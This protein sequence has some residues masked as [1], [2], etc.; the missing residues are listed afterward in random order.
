CDPHADLR[1]S[2][3]FV[4]FNCIEECPSGSLSFKLLPAGR[5]EI[6]WPEVPGRRAVLA[7]VAGLLLYPF[8]RTSGK[9]TRDYSSKVIRPPGT[10]EELEFLERCIK[11]DQCVR[12]CPTNVLQPAGMEA[13]VEGVW[14]PVMNFRMGHCQL[15]CTAC[16]QVCPTGAI[17][18]ISLEE[19]LG[20]GEFT[21]RGPIRLGTAH[22]DVG[23]CLPYSKN[24]PCVV[25]EEVCPTSP[26]AIHTE[27]MQRLVRDGRKMVVDSSVCTAT[28]SEWPA[29]GQA[30]G[31]PVLLEANEWRGNETTSYHLQ[32]RHADGL[33]ESHRIE[34]ND[35]DTVLIAG[36]FARIP[37]PGAEVRINLEYKV[38]KIDASLC[39]GCGL[40]ERECPV[41]GDRRAV[42]VT[43]EGETRSEGY[44][45]RDRNRSVRLIKTASAG[46]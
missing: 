38:P 15:N 14:T 33:T 22:F 35:T 2:E 36:R 40:C 29:P 24:I 31:R 4:C 11:C 10:V 30:A 17:Q 18:R 20:L 19:K 9:A 16:G 44:P 41:V 1:K 3:C 13:G 27:R 5:D 45:Q 37:E 39:I 26:K 21:A 6:A 25:C 12:V 8:A 28:L 32:V 42:Y 23:R 34:G 43:P 7:G 46:T